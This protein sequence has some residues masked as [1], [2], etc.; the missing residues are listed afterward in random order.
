MNE[1]ACGAQASNLR[2]RVCRLAAGGTADRAVC[3]TLASVTE[4]VIQ[5]PEPMDHEEFSGGSGDASCLQM[6][7]LHA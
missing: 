3:A 2:G 5:K 6:R 7:D 4:R 1:A